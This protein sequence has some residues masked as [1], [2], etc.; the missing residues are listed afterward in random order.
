V[1]A[2]SAEACKLDFGEFFINEV[3]TK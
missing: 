1:R 3:K 2:T